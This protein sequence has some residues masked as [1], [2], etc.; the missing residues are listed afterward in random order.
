MRFSEQMCW[1]LGTLVQNLE[2]INIICTRL[3]RGL[4]RL[5]RQMMARQTP[6]HVTRRHRQNTVQIS[7]GAS[8]IKY[9]SSLDKVVAIHKTICKSNP[10]EDPL[11]APHACMSFIRLMHGCP[12]LITWNLPLLS[13]A[14]DR[15][16]G[17]PE[18]HFL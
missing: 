17:Y 9:C 14:S 16:M 2:L 4:S 11:I 10:T 7:V 18:I 3:G 12:V 5:Q 1:N 15:R 8:G 13:V 6:E